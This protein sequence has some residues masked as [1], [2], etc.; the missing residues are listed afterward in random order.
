MSEI[1]SNSG[2]NRVYNWEDIRRDIEDETPKEDDSTG[3][4]SPG[5]I[6]TDKAHPE[7]EE[8]AR[9]DGVV[10]EILFRETI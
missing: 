8:Y 4:Y 9:K 2:G 3:V 5:E 1:L 6:T 10:N 7:W